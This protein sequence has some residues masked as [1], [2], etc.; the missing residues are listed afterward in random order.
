MKNKIHYGWF[1]FI[2]CCIMQFTIVGA[3]INGAGMFY[4]PICEELGF[5]RGE[6][7]L[8]ATIS[9]MM[10]ALTAPFWGKVMTKLPIKVLLAGCLIVDSLALVV[11]SMGTQLWHWYVAAV[12]LGTANCVLCMLITP[13]I[14][15]N[16]FKKNLGLV[17]GIAMSF[18]G[19]GGAL[20]NQLN[21][22]LIEQFGWRTAQLVVALMPVVLVLPY[23]LIFYKMR[24]E[25]MG[26][27]PY[28]AEESPLA[29]GK[30]GEVTGM[31]MQQAFKSILFPL[32]LV[33]AA[34]G[35]FGAGFPNFL[36]SIAVSL[37]KPLSYGATMASMSMIGNIAGKLILG[38]INDKM[39]VKNAS[40]ASV[41]FLL[42][43]HICLFAGVQGGI[44]I[45]LTAGAFLSGTAMSLSAVMVP[46]VAKA[47]FGE[48]DYS[49]IYSYVSMGSS[50]AV[51]AASS[52]VG[53]TYDIF[54]TYAVSSVIAIVIYL[55]CVFSVLIMFKKKAQE[56]AKSC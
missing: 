55:I 34:L 51:A 10:M 16:W 33:Y 26:L 15:N 30:K 40:L 53:F 9:S 19:I 1:M 8:Y 48:R 20:V 11:M 14:L 21:A 36:S 7:A 44:G 17:T 39:G 31:T 50:L 54:G 45:L 3:V 23:V 12:F 46:L 28:G 37:G 42:V 41:L 43:C 52:V 25:D 18:S 27:K 35:S 6:L 29:E 13:V 2:G 22:V 38:W 5:G 24:P 47:I 4:T 32:V 56:D 49:S